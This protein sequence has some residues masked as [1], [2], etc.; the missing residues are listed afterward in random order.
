MGCIDK[1]AFAENVKHA[2]DCFAK[3]VK[4]FSN[5]LKLCQVVGQQVC[6]D[7]RYFSEVH[8]VAHDVQEATESQE[9]FLILVLK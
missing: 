7:V 1:K 8:P 6:F 9:K 2:N 3:E 5:W 4:Y